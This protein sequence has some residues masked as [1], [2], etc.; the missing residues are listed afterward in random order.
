MKVLEKYRS[1]SLPGKAAVW[2]VVC[3][4][5]NKGISLLATP[6]LTRIMSTEQYGT[7]SVFQSWVAIVMIFC[8]LNLFGAAYSRGRLDYKGRENA[9][10][11][12]LLS[13][14]TMLTLGFFVVFCFAPDFWSGLMGLTPFLVMLLFVE[15]LL[16]SAT[17]FWS[18]QQRFEYRYRALVI[19]TIA[20]NIFSIGVGIL[21]IMNTDAKVEARVVMDV[22]AKG[23]PGLFL[24]ALIFARGRCFFNKEYWK[25]G[26]VFTLP[27]VPH[28]I[29]H[30]VLNQS[31]R[32]MISMMVDNTAAALYSVAYSIS[33]ALVIVMNAIND[34]YVPYVFQEFDRGRIEGARRNGYAVLMLAGALTLL[35]M[36][37]APEILAVFGGAEYA[38]AEVVI[39]PL[40][41]SV[42]FIFLYSMVSNIEYYFKKTRLI[43]LGSVVAALLNVVLNLIFIPVFGYVA[44]GWTT[45]ASYVVLALM[46]GLFSFKICKNEFGRQVY[47]IQVLC[48]MSFAVLIVSIGM[49]AVLDVPIARYFV[50]AIVV[51]VMLLK[52]RRIIEIVRRKA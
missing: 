27:L 21:A 23:V 14:S 29:S 9:F 45:L 47:S 34:S 1:M 26:L 37:F 15:V 31:D 13:L 24:M 28:F 8:T 6:I 10:E 39:P 44:A 40:A 7:F 2:F 50:I 25:F 46:H 41:A 35:V 30:Y 48:L 4:V 36:A 22:V 51:A 3:N 11:S 20:T 42:F 18:A 33:M 38:D 49:L 43:A 19:V 16:S 5:A 52:R 12:S 17:A 32:L